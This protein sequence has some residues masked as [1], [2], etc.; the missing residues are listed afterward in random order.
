MPRRLVGLLIM[1]ALVAAP[2][3]VL[4]AACV[5][6]TC[7]SPDATQARVPFCPLPDRLKSLISAGYRDKRS[8]DVLAVPA[9]PVAG[10]TSP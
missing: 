7:G 4:R 9:G 1:S 8:P 5:G 3:V 6:K 10:G 2:A